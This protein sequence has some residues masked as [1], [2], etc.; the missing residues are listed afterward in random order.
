[1][2]LLVKTFQQFPSQSGEF[3]P[4]KRSPKNPMIFHDFP[5]YNHVTGHT[6]QILP[7]FRTPKNPLPKPAKGGSTC[8]QV[9]NLGNSR[10]GLE[11]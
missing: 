8:E 5:R 2:H 1:M 11:C 9:D 3:S 7:R 10:F 6:S 4:V